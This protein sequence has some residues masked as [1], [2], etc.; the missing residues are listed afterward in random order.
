MQN[1]LQAVIMQPNFKVQE[2]PWRSTCRVEVLFSL[3]NFLQHGNTIP[4]VCSSFFFFFFQGLVSISI[5][6]LTSLCND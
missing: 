3:F 4:T 1:D 2:E 5:Q 6:K